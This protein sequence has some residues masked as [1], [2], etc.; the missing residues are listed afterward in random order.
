MRKQIL[1]VLA[2]LWTFAILFLCLRSSNKLPHLEFPFLD[3]II[4]FCFHFVFVVLW[5]F[6][7]SCRY[8]HS[9]FANVLLG[10][11]LSS[12]FFGLAIEI[13]Q[14]YFTTTRSADV[15]DIFSNILGGL[16]AIVSLVCFKLFFVR[17]SF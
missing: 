5:F 13:L 8:V 14:Q 6:Y 12:F 2:L 1:L 7:I 16:F 11:M 3:K 17:N 9:K 15:Y 4:H 10:C